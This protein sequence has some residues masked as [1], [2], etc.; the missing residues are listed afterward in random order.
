MKIVFSG[1]GTLGSVTPLLAVAEVAQEKNSNHELLWLGTKTGPERK[2]VEAADIK[3]VGITSGRLRRFLTLR[4][5]ATPF[6]VLKGLYDAWSQLRLFRPDAVVSA[7]GFVAVPV[8][9]AAWLLRIPAHIHQMD[10]RPGLANRLSV[11]FAKSVSATFAKSREDFG[12]KKITVTGNPIRRFLFSGS[13]EKARRRFRLRE[14]LPIVLVIGGGTGAV[15][16]NRLVMA[17]LPALDGVQIIHVVGR[18]KSYPTHNAPN[19]YHQVEFL[20]EEIADAYAAAR[21]VVTRA[22]MG[23]L[24]EL[25]ALGLPA[26]VVPIQNSHQEENARYYVEH[27]GAVLFEESGSG[28][29]LAERVNYLLQNPYELRQL[30]V[31]MSRIND[32]DAA[33]RVYELIVGNTG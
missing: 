27:G 8:V 31:A 20:S 32:S 14:E 1:G 15:N 23:T 5:L 19:T 16:L 10:W 29:K 3:Y 9:W 7:G 2:M 13:A 18:G 24:T 12:G 22:G 25:A 26:V 21:L 4:N 28:D 33:L 6:L 30:S 11:P 17:A